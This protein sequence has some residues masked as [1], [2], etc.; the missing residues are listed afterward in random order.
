MVFSNDGTCLVSGS[1]GAVISISD[2]S[3]GDRVG[4]PL[5]GHKAAITAVIFNPND[6]RIYSSSRDHSIR[7]WDAKTR[8]S[9]KVMQTSDEVSSMALS[10]DG[11][12]LISGWNSGITLWDARHGVAIYAIPNAHDG[13]VR[14]VGFSPDG[15]KVVSASQDKSI[16]LWDATDDWK[17]YDVG[18]SSLRGH[19]SAVTSVAFLKGGRRLVSSS[20]D[21]TLR[22]WDTETGKTAIGPLE[23]HADIVSCVAVHRSCIASCSHDGTFRIWD[24]GSGALVLGPIPAHGGQWLYWIAYSRDGTRIATAGQDNCAILWDADTGAP[25]HKMVGH[26]APVTCVA[27]AEDGTRLVSG[28]KDKNIHIWNTASGIRLGEPLAGHTACVSAVCFSSNGKRVFSSSADRTIR[29]WDLDTRASVIELLPSELLAQLPGS[30]LRGHTDS[31]ISVAFLPDG[32]RLV[33]SSADKT[34]RIWDIET[35]NAVIGPLVGHT[36][37][38]VVLCVAFSEDGTRLVSGSWDE[39]VRIW[40]VASGE[41]IGEPYTEHTSEVT[42]VCFSPD[43]THIFSSS[44]DRTIRIWDAETRALI[45]EPLQMDDSVICMA[46]SPDGKRLVSGS[47]KGKI[48]MWDAQTGA[49]IPTA[50]EGHKDC[51]NSVAFSPDRRKIASASEDKMIALW[52]ATDDWKRW[53]IDD[54]DVEKDDD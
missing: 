10:P 15:R 43:D 14:A 28:S 32:R 48:A 54:E 29:I 6:T 2:L 3:T 42:A 22:I 39:T 38:D 45:V 26:S 13:P 1:Q 11:K 25:L 50:I 37:L 46:P 49:A 9:I 47:I 41:C 19:S 33:S 21:K 23:G 44:C 30:P 20:K 27:F 17:S 34:L 7:I 52:D 18:G 51:V 12:R 24:A 35:G 53:D 36:D 5:K 16:A 40:D 8:R 31:V 4:G